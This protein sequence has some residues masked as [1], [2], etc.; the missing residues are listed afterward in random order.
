MISSEVVQETGTEEGKEV[1][2]MNCEFYPLFQLLLKKNT[3]AWLAKIQ[4]GN[5]VRSL[6]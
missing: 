3:V 5:F 4:S 1:L 2:C 6:R